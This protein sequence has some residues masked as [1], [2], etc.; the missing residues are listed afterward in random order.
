MNQSLHA[1]LARVSAASERQTPLI[2]ICGVAEPEHARVAVEAGA[3]FVGVVFYPPSIRYVSIEQ[4]R[5][6]SEVV[7]Q[8]GQ[9]AVRV[10]GLFVNA[11]V[12]EM[13]ATADEVGLD[14]IQLSGSEGPE[15]IRELTR[16]VIGT[17]RIGSTGGQGEERAFAAWGD[18]TPQPFAIMIDSH[19]PGMYGGT[20]TLSDWFVAAEFA[21][22]YPIVLAGGLDPHNVVSAIQRVRPAIV[23][24]SSGVESSGRKDSEK[25]RAFVQAARSV[26][27]PSLATAGGTP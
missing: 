16:P 12:E 4:A 6:V 7:H 8:S 5:A 1:P 20:G 14:L 3:D 13:N 11:S 17:V 2:K 21:L 18:A 27:M 23:D 25:I 26:A 9:G 19:V 10:V 24:V 15:L 22:R